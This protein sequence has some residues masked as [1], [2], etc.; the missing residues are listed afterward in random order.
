MNSGASVLHIVPTLAGRM[1]GVA[2]YARTLAAGLLR[3]QAV[4]S[5]YLCGKTAHSSPGT[6]PGDRA[7]WIR[8]QSAANLAE[9]LARCAA[10]FPGAGS[11]VV[12][13]HYVNYGYEKRGCPIW[14]IRGLDEWKRRTSRARLV[15]MFHE[16]YAFS[17]PWRSAFWLSPLQRT[18]AREL[19]SLSDAVVTNREQS[20]RWLTR[21]GS[22]GPKQV[23]V[24]PVFS[25]LG[26]LERPPA[27]STRQRKMVVAGRSGNP[28]RAYSRR[29]D[30]LL[31]ACRAMGIDEIVDIGARAGPVPER[32][33]EIPVTVMG[34]LAAE[35][36][37]A[38]LGSAR[39]GFL[40]YPSDFLAKSTVF[41]A[42]AAH[43]LVPVVS[44]R[45]GEEETGLA[46][47][48]NYWVPSDVAVPDGGF[49]RI[50]QASARWYA[51]HRL[52][53]QVRAYADLLQGGA[54]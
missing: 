25:C 23:E 40:D 21:G 49:E 1:D 20:R 18:L 48:A 36:A 50:A 47:G 44:W 31:R 3:D 46:Q 17:P 7:T 29:R 26:E 42:Y 28:D 27:W 35:Q 9:A 24:M 51:E 13:V 2:D 19:F 30:Q 6:E 45:R 4:Q 38:L 15:T 53:V 43:G 12:L 32:V 14:L 41:A 16:L 39:A 10:E 5:R 8:R 34:H 22:H 54:A 37:S 52:A 11:F 33:G